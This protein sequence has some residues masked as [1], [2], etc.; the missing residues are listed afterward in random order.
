MTIPPVVFV[1]NN[2]EVML[3]IAKA[4]V[5]AEVVTKLTMVEVAV[6]VAVM[7]ATVGEVDEVMVVPSDDNH[8][9]PNDV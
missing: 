3:V 8:P 7:Y 1:F 9:C 4:V 6:E 5:D 2:D